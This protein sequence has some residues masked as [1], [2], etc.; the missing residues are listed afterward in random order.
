MMSLRFLAMVASFRQHLDVPH[1]EVQHR[2][3]SEHAKQGRR[4]DSTVPVHP[5]R[6][7]GRRAKSALTITSKLEAVKP[8]TTLDSL[9]E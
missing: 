6:A 1:N 5:T 7:V 3:I 4:Q 2:N 8:H 9:A